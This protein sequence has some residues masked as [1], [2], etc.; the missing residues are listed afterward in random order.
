MIKLVAI[1]L[2]GTLFNSKSQISTKN[3]EAILCCL[4]NNIRVIITTGKTI[5]SVGKLVKELGLIDLQIASGGSVIIDRNLNPIQSF[6]IPRESVINIVNLGRNFDKGFAMCC[7]D[8]F[9]YYEKFHDSFKYITETGDLM[10]KIDNL[11]DEDIIKS[12]LMFV[13][14]VNKEDNF[15]DILMDNINNDVKVRRGGP[16]F[17]N[18]LNKEAGKVSAIKKVLKIYNI[19]KEYIMSIGDSESDMGIIKFAGFGVAMGNAS[20]TVKSAADAVV[21]SNDD[22][23][24]AEAIYKFVLAH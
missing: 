21:G 16:N 8:G 1:D 6:P 3:K 18:V 5:Y 19:D 22:G 24:V 4:E 20:D 7:L 12:S 13:A 15:N 9:I 2:D 10:I 23:G 14:T 17:L 11:L